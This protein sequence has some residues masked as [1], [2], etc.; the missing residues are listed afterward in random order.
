ME[1]KFLG[2]GGAFDNE[3]NSSAYCINEDG[4]LFIDMGENVFEKAKEVLNKLE[5]K[6]ARIGVAIT[7]THSDHV[8]SLGTFVLY[9]H[10]ILRKP[11]FLFTGSEAQKKSIEDLLKVFGVSDSMYRISHCHIYNL[12]IDFFKT[13]HVNDFDC[14]GI[15]IRDCKLTKGIYFSGDSNSIPAEIEV[16][17]MNG[18]IQKFYQDITLANYPGNV[19][20]NLDKFVSDFPAG[21][22]GKTEVHFYH[23]TIFDP[24]MPM[25]ISK[26][27]LQSSSVVVFTPENSQELLK[28][29]FNSFDL[30]RNGIKEITGEVYGIKIKYVS[31]EEKEIKHGD[32]IMMTQT[33]NLL[34]F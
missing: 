22:V 5:N 3:T 1:L 28:T 11:V 26:M 32:K 9:C 29:Y 31:G 19:H 8:G 15:L 6:D 23:N 21:A 7:H 2:R 12:K 30:E 25:D 18:E 33:G 4:V 20:Y 27:K 34:F 13:T 14:F 10:Y 16:K 24:N 17:L